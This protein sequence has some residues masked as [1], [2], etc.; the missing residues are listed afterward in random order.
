[1]NDNRTKQLQSTTKIRFNHCDPFG[2]LNNAAYVDYFLNARED[3]LIAYYDFDLNEYAKQH[4]MAWVVASHQINYLI[5]VKNSQ[6]VTIKSC[7]INF[8]SKSVAVEFE[9][10]YKANKCATMT[11]TFVHVS[12]MKGSA[13]MHTEEWM[14]FFSEIVI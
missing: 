8:T 5:P 13:E 9:M 4:G 6:E 11:S 1:M 14:K 3:H 12:I 2:H 7:L 10:W